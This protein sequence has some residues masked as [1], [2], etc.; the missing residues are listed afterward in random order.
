MS[1]EELHPDRLLD[2]SLERTLI[3]ASEFE[4]GPVDTTTADVSNELHLDGADSVLLEAHLA[5]CAAC[6]FE[7][8]A[9]FDFLAEL[10]R[11]I[12]APNHAFEAKRRDAETPLLPQPNTPRG[13][14]Q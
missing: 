1:V 3:F 13:A 14:T 4:S 5:R 10:E 7:R 9:R 6:R 12:A 8:L 2:L 11:P